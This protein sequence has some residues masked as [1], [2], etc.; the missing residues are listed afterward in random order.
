MASSL[1]GCGSSET[2]FPHLC[3][4][5][6]NQSLDIYKKSVELN[7][8]APSRT[9]SWGVFKMA[10]VTFL[11]DGQIG[12]KWEVNVGQRLDSATLD[13]ASWRMKT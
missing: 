8:L 11:S 5:M 7:H 13:S 6:I 3:L 4:D 1:S 9:A 12:L 2:Q 10:M